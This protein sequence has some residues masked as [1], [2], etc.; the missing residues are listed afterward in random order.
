MRYRILII[1]IFLTVLI[2]P[3]AAWI[4]N[5]AYRQGFTVNGSAN[6]SGN[7][8]GYPVKITTQYG[9]GSSSG[10]TVYLKSH[11]QTDF[12]D[13]RFTTD[14]DVLC[15]YWVES[16]TDSSVAVFWFEAQSARRRVISDMRFFRKRVAKWKR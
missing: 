6:W 12:D 10:S 14:G 8:T 3:A 16:K 2:V 11:A 5:F 13:V 4:D 1:L 15:D 9:A 7:Y